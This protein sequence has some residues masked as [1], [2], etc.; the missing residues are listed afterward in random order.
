MKTFITRSTACAI[1]ASVLTLAGC[2]APG[3]APMTMNNA[4][5]GAMLGAVLGGVAGN[6]VGKGEGRT[7]ATIAGTMLGSYLGGQYG[8]Q[9]DAHDQQNLSQSLYSGRPASWQNPN[10]G[11]SYRATPGKTYRA[12]V[13]NQSTN[14]RPVSIIGT[15]DGRQQNVQM[16]ACQGANGQW[17]AVN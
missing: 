14:C 17:Q 9:F 15:I 3:S 13:N 4:Q 2:A 10:T 1:M 16:R 5:T 6:Q 8:A 12:N 7:V 11:Y